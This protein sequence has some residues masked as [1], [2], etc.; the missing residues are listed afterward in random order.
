MVFQYREYKPAGPAY[1]PVPDLVMSG[2]E[3]KKKTP[4]W[5]HALKAISTLGI[6]Y[7]VGRSSKLKPRD[8][9]NGILIDLLYERPITDPQAILEIVKRR[10]MEAGLSKS[11]AAGQLGFALDRIVSQM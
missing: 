10:M 1:I 11:Q 8:V 7:L 3:Q 2:V 4:W 6:C 5:K 9:V